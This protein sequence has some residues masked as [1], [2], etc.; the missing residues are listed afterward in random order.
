MQK[1]APND[2]L[3]LEQY[4]RQR[5]AFRAQAIAHKRAR[6][7]HLGDHLTLLFEDR[8]TVQYQVQEMLRI[9]R[10]FEPEAIAEELTAY[11]PLIPDGSNLK[12]TL[13]IEYADI[14]ERRQAL[15]RLRDVENRIELVVEGHAPIIA[16]ADEDLPRSNE[17]KTAA[18]HFLRFEL[19]SAQ[20]A[21]WRSGAAVRVR[22][23]HPHCSA[24][25]ILDAAQRASLGADLA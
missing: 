5:D 23:L 13:L 17:D 19:S 3:G 20:V 24:E 18:V 11:N 25:A 7:I 9:E 16:I 2:L 8:A 14:E 22:I 21:A 12:A 4:A 15:A 6:S 1:L 10:I